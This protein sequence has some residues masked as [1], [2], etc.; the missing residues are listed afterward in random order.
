MAQRVCPWWLGY[1]LISPIRRW[2]T[3]NPTKL[4]APYLSEGATVLEPGP[5]MGFFT[6]P[7]AR[8]A[9]ASGRIVAVDIQPKMLDR[10]RRR[11]S[12]AGLA[13]RIETRLAIPESLG[14][15]DLNGRVDFVLAFA[16]VHEMPS[17]GTFFREVAAALKPGGK[18]LFAEPS[19]HVN[20]AEFAGEKDAA[21][22]AGLDELRPLDI[23]G[24]RAALFI[25]W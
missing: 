4:L 24:S 14:I 20:P 5:G 1:F 23:R 2:G 3:E 10:L 17:A 22:D 16:M 8:L 19:G 11:A 13:E 9:G 18:L 21:R 6:L 12:K 7:M 15:A 25:Q